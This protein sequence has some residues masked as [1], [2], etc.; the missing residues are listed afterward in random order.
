MSSPISEPSLL[1]ALTPRQERVALALAEGATITAAAAA[2]GLHRSTI[3]RWLNKQE[4]TEAVRQ[5]RTAS[6]RALRDEPNDLRAH[7]RAAVHS[8]LADP[9]TPPDERLRLA[10]AILENPR[11]T[12]ILAPTSEAPTPK[13]RQNATK[14]PPM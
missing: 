14:C 2:A 1:F 7:A 6:M 11:F 12:P 8:L 5:T 9:Q 3:H 13:K 10:L 4:F